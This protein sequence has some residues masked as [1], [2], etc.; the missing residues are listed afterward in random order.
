MWKLMYIYRCWC[1]EDKFGNQIWAKNK[2]DIEQLFCMIE[3]G[4]V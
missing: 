3:N 2:S 4:N 1:A